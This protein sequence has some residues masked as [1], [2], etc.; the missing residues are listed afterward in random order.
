MRPSYL[1]LLTV[2]T[3][4]VAFLPCAS[5]QVNNSGQKPYLGWSSFSQ[6]TIDGSFLTQ[7]NMIVQSD[8]L[9]AS[10]LQEHG[11]VYINLDSG[12]QGSFDQ[13]GRP[14][15]N[16]TTFPDIKALVDHIHANG[17]KAGIYWIPGIQQPA[18][19]GKYP[20]LGTPYHTQDIVVTPL[21]KGNA[22]AG[23]PPNPYHDK[24]DFTK[25]GAQEYIDSV[26]ALFSSWG[27]D[28]IKLDGVSPG[29]YSNDLSIDNRGD[30]EAWS[31]AIAKT[32]RPIWL[33]VSW[34][35]SQDYASVWQQWSNARRIDDDVEC[36]GRCAT[37][38]N[39]PRIV[40]RE[41]ND[42]GWQ[43]ET[44]T[45]LG[46]ND[47]D[48]LDVG[49][50]PLDGLSDEEK[51]TA[52]TIWAM[53]NSPIYLGGDL[54]KL[55]AFANSALTNDEL[56]A[57]DQ[58][59]RP[60]VQVT[61]GPQPVWMS[62]QADGSI[63]VA[64]YNLNGLPSKVTVR[65]SD[66]G[67]RH[68]VAVRDVWNR[69]NLGPSP[70]AYTTT[71]LGHGSRL[72]KITPFGS[73]KA[74]AGQVY[75]AESAT[76]S[77]TTYVSPCSACSGGAK[78]SYL[79]ASPTTNN[80]TFNVYVQNAGTYRME[81]DAMTQGPRALV[82]VVN[83]NRPATLNM[84]GGS[85]NLPQ[86]STVPVTLIAGNNTITF[87][88]PG[89]YA[90][91]LDRIVISRDGSAVAPDF[92]TY[93]A[94]AARL[95]GTASV[96]GCSFC[97]GGAYV[98]NY[99]AGSQNAVTFPNVTVAEAGMYQL[100]IDYTTSGPRTFYISVND[101][102][103]TAL[104]VN[105]S[106][107]DSPVPVLLPVQLNAGAN[108]IVIA[109]PNAGGYAP[110]LDSITVGP[111]VGSSNLMAAITRKTGADLLRI[112][113]LSFTNA[114][115]AVAQRSRLNSFTLVPTTEGTGCQAK[116]VLPTPLPLGTIP[117]GAT[118]SIDLPLAFSP[119]CRDD[120][121]YRVQAIFSANYG[122]DVGSLMSTETH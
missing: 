105:G 102:P 7:A 33:T 31:K 5:A 107:F 10:G 3:G 64:L 118:G 1:S 91:D 61:G 52:I 122:A 116:P 55:D 94:E 96:G 72:L 48:T 103:A 28:F 70:V 63:Y 62:K 21:A 85:F 11:F 100:E 99:G 115:N 87:G 108:K 53:A 57:V 50:G 92:T 25:P 86:A 51:Q 89:T 114:G 109:N 58:S 75:E 17:Q 106:T 74:P 95:S 80:A 34:Q 41:Y 84:G 19:D 60:A 71:I 18:V 49:D 38:T 82:Y 23:N 26:V 56:I 27:F 9:K 15:P 13:N 20:I 47:M 117:S 119:L 2:I 77:G 110:G 120:E 30:V 22:F 104:E 44:G 88:N 6:Q 101:G 69:I 4:V 14:I 54:T 73:V 112:W 16:S 68:A 45:T 32:G 76:L 90:A 79:G 93:E 29:S 59:G 65:W 46:W 12:W 83:G 97:S 98:G 8:A 24:I 40:L 39:W 37:L 35:L 67:F 66:L 36:E 111:I 81:V 78:L 43:H 121:T 113:Q 42:V